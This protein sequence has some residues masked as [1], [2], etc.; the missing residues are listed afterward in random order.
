[1]CAQG[2][3]LAS[4]NAKARGPANESI[5][6]C[7]NIGRVTRHESEA[8]S[9]LSRYKSS[10]SRACAKLRT[11]CAILR[12]WMVIWP[13]CAPLYFAAANCKRNQIAKR[14]HHSKHWEARQARHQVPAK[15]L[16]VGKLCTNNIE[17]RTSD[18]KSERTPLLGW[19]HVFLDLLSSLALAGAVYGRQGHMQAQY[20]ANTT[21]ILRAMACR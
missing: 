8:G 13:T 18:L 3:H 11:S 9:Q 12:V 7:I 14:G 17:R 15:C 5:M 2:K 19:A 4:P 21:T 16:R 6:H 1:M 10:R 20:R